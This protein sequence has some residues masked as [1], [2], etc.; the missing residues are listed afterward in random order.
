ME[1]KNKAAIVTGASAGIGK[2]T[3]ELLRQ[4]GATVYNLDHNTPNQEDAN[5]IFCGEQERRYQ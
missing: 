1:W 3:K 4:K 5:F 2:A